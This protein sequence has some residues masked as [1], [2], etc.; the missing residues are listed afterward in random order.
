MDKTLQALFALLRAGLWGRYDEAMASAF[1]LSAQEWERVFTMARQQ[2]VTGI[3]FR[4]LDFLPEDA[5]PPMGVMA[6]WMAHADR[7][8]Q[9]N[10]VMN[11]TVTKLYGHFASA[12]VEAVLQKGQGVAAM[13]PEPLLRECGDIDFYFPG[14][15]G[16]SDP[17]A[18]ISGAVR[19]RQPDDSW[20]YVVDGIVVEHH[21]D[22]LDIQ[23]PRAKRYVKR[24]IEEKGFE[25]VVTGDGVEV[26]VPAPEVNLLL[27]SSHILKHA[28][29]VGIGLRQFCDYAVARRYY[30]RR[31]NAEEMREI[32]RMTGLEKWQELLENFLTEYLSC[33][34]ERQ[35]RI[36][37]GK[38]LHSVQNDN[39]ECHSESL[40]C[41]SEQSCRSEQSS[42]HSERSEESFCKKKTGVLLDIVLKGGNFGVYSKDR[43]NV[44]RA[45]WAR[46]VQTFKALMGNIGFAFRYA[47][48][49]WFWTTM[50]LLGGQFR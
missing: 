41:H 22:L 42:C 6:K 27:L 26:L 13:Y 23:S 12:G 25:K 33:H 43:E 10:R 47:P 4:G 11:E 35:R 30:E 16:V 40:L 29:G 17:L 38:I 48:G 50:Q 31:V 7:I 2:T 39:A 5:A 36:F 49:E 21:T 28:F 46:K 8:E 20:S 32:W 18:G 45:R 3:A 9:S 24:L 19:E 1:P 15:D 44:P 34:P 14:H 37:I